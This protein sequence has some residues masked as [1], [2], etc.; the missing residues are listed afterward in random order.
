MDRGMDRTFAA[1]YVCGRG[2]PP[3]E[4]R[5]SGPLHYCEGCWREMGV[6]DELEEALAR[7][8]DE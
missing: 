7:R 4:M 8:K 3:S 6:A 1:C 5:C 2:F